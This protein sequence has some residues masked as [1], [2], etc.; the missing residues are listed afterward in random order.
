MMLLDASQRDV[1]VMRRQSTSTPLQALLMLNDPQFVEPA[2]VWAER[3]VAASGQE[4]DLL[5]G[6]FRR[7]TSRAATADELQILTLALQEQR[8]SYRADPQR[9]QQTATIGDRKPAADVD[10]VEVASWTMVISMLL[11][12]D[13]VVRLR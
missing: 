1:C 11:N 10:V 6:V 4:Q 2:R 12:F 13:E 8:E 5:A 7:L 3:L 9:A